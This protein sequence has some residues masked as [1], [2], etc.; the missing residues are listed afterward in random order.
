[1]H[2]CVNIPPFVCMIHLYNTR[3]NKVDIISTLMSPI[4]RYDPNNLTILSVY[5]SRNWWYDW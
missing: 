5:L 1:M 3:V 2:Q 4:T